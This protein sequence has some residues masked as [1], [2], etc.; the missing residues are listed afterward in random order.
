MR[1]GSGESLP[2]RILRTGTALSFSENLGRCE[3]GLRNR[4]MSRDRF[5]KEDRMFVRRL[6]PPDLDIPDTDSPYFCFSPF[7]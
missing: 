4:S 6:L 7:S 1:V 2:Y 3:S 5:R